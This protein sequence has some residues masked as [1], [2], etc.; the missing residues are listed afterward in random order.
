[1]AA[2]GPEVDLF[3][4]PFVDRVEVMGF[5]GL[6]GNKVVRERHSPQPRETDTPADVGMTGLLIHRSII[7]ANLYRDSQAAFSAAK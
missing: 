6:H 5:A 3:S 1:M 2:F 4:G 7:A